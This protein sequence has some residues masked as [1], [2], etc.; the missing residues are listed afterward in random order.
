[1][2]RYAKS[3]EFAFYVPFLGKFLEEMP[4]QQ[5]GMNQE[6]EEPGVQEMSLG[7][8]SDNNGYTAGLGTSTH[9]AATGCRAPGGCPQEKQ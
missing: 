1:M 6:E 8:S 4:H 5:G 3:R 9:R 7:M 2:F